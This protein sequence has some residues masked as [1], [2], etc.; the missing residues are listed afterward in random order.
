MATMKQATTLTYKILHYVRW[1]VIQ[2]VFIG[3]GAGVVISTT[4]PGAGFKDSAVW[5]IWRR[6]FLRAQPG[7]LHN[8]SNTRFAAS[9]EVFPV[10]S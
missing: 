4:N 2:R 9:R 3:V 1:L 6:Y 5:R 7:K 8:I 10:V